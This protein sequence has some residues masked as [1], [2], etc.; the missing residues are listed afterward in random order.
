[1][2]RE[3]RKMKR[4]KT[5]KPPAAAS[6]APGNLSPKEKRALKNS[7]QALNNQADALGILDPLE[8]E[9]VLIYSLKEG[10]E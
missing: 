1:M 10:Q 7:I 3:R 9:P 4:K 2:K 6:S 8:L 5:L